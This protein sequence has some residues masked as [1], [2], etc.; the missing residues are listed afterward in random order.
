MK[1]QSPHILTN[2]TTHANISSKGFCCLLTS[3]EQRKVMSCMCGK[4]RTSENH[5][6]GCWVTRKLFLLK[7]EP[8]AGVA[9]FS[10]HLSPG[11]VQLARCGGEL[12]HLVSTNLPSWLEA[13]FHMGQTWLCFNPSRYPFSFFL[14]PHVTLTAMKDRKGLLR[15]AP[16]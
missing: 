12:R 15:K 8:S 9:A 4:F 7:Q 10:L 3:W 11:K 13:S 14:M 2:P 1:S 6:H 5:P 16:T